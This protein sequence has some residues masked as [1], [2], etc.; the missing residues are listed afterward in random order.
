MEDFIIIDRI[1]EYEDFIILQDS[2]G[3][4]DVPDL[5]RPLNIN[6]LKINKEKPYILIYHTH[7]TESYSSLE[8]K[9]H[10]TTDK[11]FNVLTIG[12]IVAKTLERNGHK[13]E[14]VKIS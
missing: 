3:N 8:N 11:R 10:H 1:E 12:E 9:L 5:P 2:E 4:L 13:V 7:G 14:H 6:T